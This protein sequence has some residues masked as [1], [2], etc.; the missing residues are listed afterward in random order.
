MSQLPAN[1]ND[2]FEATA[3]DLAP[4][5]RALLD[6]WSRRE[7]AR[8]IDGSLLEG[9]ERQ[10]ANRPEAAAVVNGD[11]SVS[12]GEL[13]AAADKTACAL[14]A[15]GIRH[16]DFVGAFCERSPELVALILGTWKCGAVYVP[17]DPK[18]PSQ[19]LRSILDDAAPSL[20]V[21]DRPLAAEIA[22]AG[23][24]TVCVDELNPFAADGRHAKV[25]P[26]DASSHAITDRAVVLYTSGSTGKPKG[27]VLTH[28][29]LANHNAHVIR[30]LGLRPGDRR[31]AIASINFDASLEEHFCT[32]NAGATLVLPAADTLD[33]MDGF[34]KFIET[35]RLSGFFVTT[36]LWREMTNYCY[37][38]R[39][40]LPT[41]LRALMVGGE[42][43]SL[44]VYRRFLQVG[45]RRIRWFNVYGPTETAIY[46]ST[47]EHDPERDAASEDAPPIGRPLDN[48]LL[49][50]LDDDGRL[51]AP[52]AEGELYIGGAGVAEGYLGREDITR[53]R[54]VENPSADIPPGRYYRT[55]DL[56]RFRPDGNLEY[57]CRLDNQVKLRGF[58]IEPGEIEATLLDHPTVR[59]A[60]VTV[61]TS[62]AAT[63]YLAAYVVLQPGASWSEEA[64]RLFAQGRLPDYMVPQTFL[65]LERMPQSANGKIDRK[66]L[67]EPFGFEPKNADEGAAER[68]AASV[69]EER[70]LDVWRETFQLDELGPHEDFFALG[71]DSLKAMSLTARLEA[72]TGRKVTPTM[73]FECRTAGRLAAALEHADDEVLPAPVLLREGDSARPLFFLHSLAGDVWIYRET[74]AALRTKQAVYGIQIPGLNDESLDAPVDDFQTLA[75]GYIAQVRA[76]QP[77]GPYRFA[78][79][80]SGGWMGYE[81]ARQL[82]AAGEHVEFLGLLDAGVPLKLERSLTNSRLHRI[83][84]LRR[85]LPLYLAELVRMAPNERRRALSRCLRNAAAAVRRLL[86]LPGSSG[87]ALES[88]QEFLGHFAEDI[89]FFSPARLLLIQKYFGVIERYDAGPLNGP[90]HLFRAARQPLASVQTDDLGWEHLVQGPIHV[91][92]ITGTHATLMYGAHALGLAAAIDDELERLPPTKAQSPRLYEAVEA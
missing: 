79:Y 35:E 47:Y 1:T 80:S 6:R 81:M 74:A 12:F 21:C 75:R 85:N 77:L 19:R 15:R 92:A 29:N 73:L 46:S 22:P 13:R 27:V 3:G 91:R 52:G 84:A 43:A 82:E 67:P 24:A 45:G 70:V 2:T 62:P 28:R 31:T 56:V 51:V 41:T 53:Q 30:M 37:E 17:L 66:A 36:S 39:R 14:L 26:F 78:G 32:L 87:V 65:Q 61:V 18:Y 7:P 83:R 34:L 16:G 5:A 68:S 58:R 69:L 63:R 8:S 48:T 33:S 57:V 23:Q 72:T 76:I 10:A 60:V 44:A 90:V 20:V 59:D 88:N 50:L 54:F 4:E 49:Y 25:A 38:T 40:E 86:G 11:R 9:F 42:Q 64:L 89:S 71:G 55:G